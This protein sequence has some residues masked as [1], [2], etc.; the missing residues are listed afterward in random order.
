MTAAVG[1]SLIAGRLAIEQW[2]F[3]RFGN[4]MPM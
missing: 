1:Y 3:W 4:F 2:D